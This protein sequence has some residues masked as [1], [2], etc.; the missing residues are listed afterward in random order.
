MGPMKEYL[1]PS[2]HR[3]TTARR[4]SNGATHARIAYF[5]TCANQGGGPRYYVGDLSRHPLL[6]GA[7]Y[8]LFP[9]EI[10]PLAPIS[11]PNNPFII[12]GGQLGVLR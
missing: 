11:L 1:T 5:Y 12:G 6:G 8:L 10:P 2:E 7:S 9:E 4:L 3:C